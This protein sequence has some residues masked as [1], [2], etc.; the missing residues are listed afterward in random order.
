LAFFKMVTF[1]NLS[2]DIC[3]LLGLFPR[4]SQ[5]GEMARCEYH[6]HGCREQTYPHGIVYWISQP[7]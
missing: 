3:L 6:D 2:S 5:I 1:S 4:G 7:L